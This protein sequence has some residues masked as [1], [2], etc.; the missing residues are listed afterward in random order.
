M[1]K[2]IY[3]KVMS[4]KVEAWAFILF[5]LL[6]AVFFVLASWLVWYKSMGGE[7][8][9]ALGEAVMRIAKAPDPFIQMLISEKKI[10]KV[11]QPQIKDFAEFEGFK[12]YRTGVTDDGT[13]L[14]SAFSDS[15][16]VSSVFLY[17]L[18]TQR[19]LHEWIPP[20]D[21]LLAQTQHR[22]EESKKHNFRSQH[23]LLLNNGDVLITSGE[24][25]LMQMDV[26]G[27]LL[28]SVDRHFHHS[29]ER[30]KTGELYI[31]I[32]S[33][34][35]AL[36]FPLRND[37][38]AKLS[39][40]GK[41]LKEWS[42]YEILSR[43]GYK[44]MLNGFGRAEFDRIHLNDIEPIEQDDQFVKKDDLM[45][46][47]RNLSTVFLYRPSTDQIVWLKT[48][49]W[50]HQHDV[51]YLGNGFYS[52]YGN[53]MIRGESA[54]YSYRGYN[55]IWRYDQ[56]TDQV[57]EF[58]SLKE[59]GINSLTE[60]RHRVL[61]SGDIIVEETN[62]GLIHRVNQEGRLWSYSH[63]LGNGKIGA[64]HWSRYLTKTESNFG[65]LDNLQCDK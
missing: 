43:Q 52:I 16:G 46:S 37:G 62:A 22:N 60:G 24:G 48:G 4:F 63:G 31:P 39:A 49:P 38:I 30:S 21:A 36:P 19:I 27:E 44:S 34:D 42:I 11:I 41:I 18:A 53:D 50:L 51:D 55:T 59:T 40:E 17:D 57:S 33:A 13:L 28:W 8:G 1:K 54:D 35:L 6:A 64:L 25:P 14:I 32:I 23:P 15:N 61:E 26:C 12:A 5:L 29:I 20:V 56:S 65:W 58:L 3:E 47:V 10:A 9:G 7:K 2:G 45:I